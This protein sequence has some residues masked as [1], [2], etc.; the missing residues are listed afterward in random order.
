MKKFLFGIVITT[1]TLSIAHCS[2][3][4]ATETLSATQETGY[5]LVG[6]RCDVE[7]CLFIN[8]TEQNFPIGVATITGYYVQLE[9]SAFEQ[10][11]QC[12]SFV[13]TEGSPALIQSLL[14]LIESGNTVYTKNDLNQAVISLDLSTLAVPEKEQVILSGASRPVSLTLLATGPTAQDAPVCFSHFEILRVK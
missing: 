6:E 8:P 13:L 7:N 2:S 11:K 4:Q 12:D 1:L 5:T 10:T 9:R 3:P 14:S